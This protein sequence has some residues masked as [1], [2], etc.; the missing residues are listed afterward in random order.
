MYFCFMDNSSCI[1]VFADAAQIEACKDK[2]KEVDQSVE[3]LANILSLAGNGVRLKILYLL[4][5]EKQLCVCDLSDIL[6]MNISAISQH[7][8]K[9]KDGR[10]IQSKK[11][12]Q[13]VF[14]TLQPA[15]QTLLDPF[16][17]LIDHKQI[18]ENS[19]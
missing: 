11:T 13:T 4:N 6:E 1:R 7:L 8:R 3:Q 14:Y 16:F 17:E 9:L 5:Q 18:L 19:L 12:G 10:V 15:Y 2:I